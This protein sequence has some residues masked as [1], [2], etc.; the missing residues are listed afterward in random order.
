MLGNSTIVRPLAPSTGSILLTSALSDTRSNP[1]IDRIHG[2]DCTVRAKLHRPRA[3]GS[4]RQNQHCGLG[5]GQHQGW[6]RWSLRLAVW[7][8]AMVV[9]SVVHSATV[10]N[11]SYN[12]GGLQR[13][14]YSVMLHRNREVNSSTIRGA[15][16]LQHHRGGRMQL[17][18]NGLCTDRSKRI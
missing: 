15:L 9:A 5:Q 3:G 17:R 11:H 12:V 4:G 1:G 6:V 10:R 18:L 8:Q 16:S 13:H 14:M 7:E 2:Q